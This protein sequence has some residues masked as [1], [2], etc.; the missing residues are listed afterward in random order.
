LLPSIV[1][2]LG[3]RT[4]SMEGA[5]F[6]NFRGKHVHDA[7]FTP[8][9]YIAYARRQ[10]RIP[11]FAVPEGVILC[12]QP[13]LLARICSTQETSPVESVFGEFH[14]LGA[15]AGRVGVVGKFGIGAPAVTT[16]FEELIAIGVRRFVSIGTAGALA[17]ALGVGDA[18][19]CERAIRDE[20]VSHHYLE[21][22]K[23]A[24]ASVSI[25]DEL[26]Q[27]LREVGLEPVRGTSWT[28]DTP[29]RETVAEA[30][31][32]QQEGVLTVE[33]EA[34]ALFAVAQYRQVELAAAFV[35]SDLLADLVWEPQFHDD[36]TL[37][38]LDL[39]FTAALRT[40]D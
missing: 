1:V 15:T 7:F 3:W 35:V 12:Y 6:P 13:S 21:P 22:A 11:D 39:L 36:R 32:Y 34:A 16:V 27:A 17:K 33:M 20:G 24:E 10:G 25:T 38:G 18:V 31:H 29:F 37:N 4:E 8:E 19:L 14:L 5:S 30:R 9:E 23:Y 40:L 28:I 26:G 2:N